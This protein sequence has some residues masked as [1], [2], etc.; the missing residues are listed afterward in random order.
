[1]PKD[2]DVIWRKF[3]TPNT[4][5]SAFWRITLSALFF[6]KI[7]DHIP[8]GYVQAKTFNGETK[9]THT[10]SFSMAYKQNAKARCLCCSSNGFTIFPQKWGPRLR[11]P[12]CS[13]SQCRGEIWGPT[14]VSL[15]LK[16]LSA[17]SITMMSASVLMQ[18][19]QP[20]LRK[21]AEGSTEKFWYNTRTV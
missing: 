11:I 7:P 16:T 4:Y 20:L 21:K 19:G 1:M 9:D 13:S 18:Q 6:N 2:S 12:S 14:P 5:C 17:G 15:C 8:K 10:P 3:L